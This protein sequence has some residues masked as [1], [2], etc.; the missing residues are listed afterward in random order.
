LVEYG[1]GATSVSIIDPE[2]VL[3]DV[4]HKWTMLG[5]LRPFASTWSGEVANDEGLLVVLSSTPAQ[6]SAYMTVVWDRNAFSANGDGDR[7]PELDWTHIGIYRGEE[8]RGVW[9]RDGYLV[10]STARE[11]QL[12]FYSQRL[13]FARAGKLPAAVIATSGVPAGPV[14]GGDA[15]TADIQ[16]ATLSWST[17]AAFGPGLLVNGDPNGGDFGQMVVTSYD[18]ALTVRLADKGYRMY[19]WSQYELYRGLR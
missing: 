9:A 14:L 12:T 4:V 1:T 18:G 7:E 17:G 6:G 19:D 10:Y 5:D 13:S 15:G 2:R 3:V 11:S 16:P 8:L